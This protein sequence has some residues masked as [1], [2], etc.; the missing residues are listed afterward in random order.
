MSEEKPM[1]PQFAKEDE[2]RRTQPRM[3]RIWAMPS[4]WTFQI[5]VIKSF[6][7]GYMTDGYGWFDP[8]AGTNPFHL[9]FSNDL[10]TEHPTTYHMDAVDFLLELRKVNGDKLMKGGL[11]DP[12]Y[13]LHQTNQVYKGF[14]VRKPI[15]LTKD[16]MAPL[17]EMGGYVLTF[18]HNS[19][20]MGLKRGFKLEEVLLVPHGGSHDDTICTAEKKVTEWTREDDE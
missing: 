2:E 11:F 19:G 20:G 16:L 10:N 6:I 3:S 13:T 1:F 14:G 9:R 5:K 17:V 12:P 4:P 18:G 8:F 7:L 15:S